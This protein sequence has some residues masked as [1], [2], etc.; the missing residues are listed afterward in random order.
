MGPNYP[1]HFS[2]GV[3]LHA[4]LSHYDV[5]FVNGIGKPEDSAGLGI[6]YEEFL[7]LQLISVLM[8][9]GTIPFAA[10]GADKRGRRKSLLTSSVAM[11]I[12]AALLPVLLNSESANKMTVLIF[13][14]VGMGVMGCIFSPMSAVLSELFPTNVRY[15]GS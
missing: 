5:D 7:V 14:I 12:F 9:M 15:T 6:P 10:L 8:F 4:L 13:L 11:L 3:V 2:H 1:R